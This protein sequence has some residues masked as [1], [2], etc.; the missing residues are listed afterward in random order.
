MAIVFQ[1]AGG[2]S[3]VTP[4]AHTIDIGAAGNDRL[5]VAILSDESAPVGFQ[6]TVTV[7]FKGLSLNRAMAAL[8]EV[9]GYYWEDKDG[10]IRVKHLETRTFTIDYIRLV[11]SGTGRS[12]IQRI[13]GFG[14][15]SL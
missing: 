14:L 12:G 3:G 7:D 11:R 2:T 13:Q 10:L 1:R 4:V 6:G 5:V 8:L 15:S 9:H